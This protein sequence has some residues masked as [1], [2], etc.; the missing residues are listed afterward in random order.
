MNAMSLL[1]SL[2]GNNA[3]SS[4]LGGQLLGGLMGGGG[5]GMGQPRSSSSGFG[6]NAIMGVLG[7]LAVSALTSYAKN[8]RLL[9]NFEA[10]SID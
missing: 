8:K 2:M 7:G 5:M 4:G 9:A 3:V 10:M 6:Q 1:G